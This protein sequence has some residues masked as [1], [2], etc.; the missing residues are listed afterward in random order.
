[1]ERTQRYPDATTAGRTALIDRSLA[2]RIGTPT[3]SFSELLR[4]YADSG[5]PVTVLPVHEGGSHGSFVR[6]DRPC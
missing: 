2:R 6:G 4:G 5:I 3:D 1:L